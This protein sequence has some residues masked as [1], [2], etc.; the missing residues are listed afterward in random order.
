VDFLELPERVNKFLYKKDVRRLTR[1]DRE[2][3]KRWTLQL[4]R[5]SHP[6]WTDEQVEA[7]YDRLLAFRVEAVDEWSRRFD[8][9]RQ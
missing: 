2:L 5:D 6:R 3:A 8:F 9:T 1:A 7:D 4:I